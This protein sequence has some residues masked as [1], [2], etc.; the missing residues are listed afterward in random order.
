MML[1]TSRKNPRE[2]KISLL[3][4][5]Y[6]KLFNKGR[7]RSHRVGSVSLHPPVEL[8]LHPRCLGPPGGHGLAL[9]EAQEPEACQGKDS[10]LKWTFGS[11]EVPHDQK[12]E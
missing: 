8:S 2:R 11:P 12:K 3:L 6:R 4:E 5:T 7:H 10:G 9:G 1:A